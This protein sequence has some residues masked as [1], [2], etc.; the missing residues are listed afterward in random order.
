M[1]ITVFVHLH[2]VDRQ[3]VNQIPLSM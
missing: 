1:A 3:P 2:A